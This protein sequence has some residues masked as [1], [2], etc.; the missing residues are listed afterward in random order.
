MLLYEVQRLIIKISGRFVN[1]WSNSNLNSIFRNVAVG[2]ENVSL[3]IDL[4]HPLLGITICPICHVI[5]MTVDNQ[6]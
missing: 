2:A 6:K 1:V 5:L 3:L 4:F